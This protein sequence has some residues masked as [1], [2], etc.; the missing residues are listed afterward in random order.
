MK[1]KNKVKI[2]APNGPVWILKKVTEKGF[3][4]SI[5]TEQYCLGQKE[6]GKNEKAADA[7]F[8][9]IVQHIHTSKLHYADCSPILN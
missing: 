1:I 3:S 7:L 9:E 6:F 4:V 8:K 5:E 2:D